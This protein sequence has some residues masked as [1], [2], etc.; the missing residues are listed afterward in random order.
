[1]K[2]NSLI[3]KTAIID[4]IS[5]ILDREVKACSIV[6]LVKGKDGKFEPDTMF[7][8]TTEDVQESF[9]QALLGQENLWLN[10]VLTD[11]LMEAWDKE[12]EEAEEAEQPAEPEKEGENSE[13]GIRN[14]EMGNEKLETRK[15]EE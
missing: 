6:A 13:F 9:K 10:D 4:S 5:K 14:S 7:I 11:A 15:E 8:G 3:T 2:I 1:M 12:A